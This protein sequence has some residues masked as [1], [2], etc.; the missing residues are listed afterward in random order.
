MIDIGCGSGNFIFAFASECKTAYGIDVLYDAVR[1]A[2]RAAKRLGL[3]NAHFIRAS[4]EFIP[5]RDDSLERV[6]LLDVIEHVRR[7]QQ[8]MDELA[9]I[10]L[11]NGKATITTPNPASVWPVVE[12]ISDCLR[13]GA[14]RR[15]VEY[16]SKVTA[17][18]LMRVVNR[19]GLRVKHIESVFFLSPFAAAFSKSLA[20]L[21]FRTETIR[22]NGFGMLQYCIAWKPEGERI[23]LS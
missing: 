1:F 22:R 13:M 3:E 21:L 23:G 19:S 4:A 15:F 20:K 5:I 12:Y 9:R 16:E 8:A 17:T 11:P 6:L 10:L 18:E 14:C 7:P 2:H